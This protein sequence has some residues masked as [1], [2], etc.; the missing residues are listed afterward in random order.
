M[1]RANPQ[2]Y[3]TNS[4]TCLYERPDGSQFRGRT[5][6]SL[7]VAKAKCTYIKKRLTELKNKRPGRYLFTGDCSS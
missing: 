4:K 5:K 6:S 1:P 7:N 3:V 2:V